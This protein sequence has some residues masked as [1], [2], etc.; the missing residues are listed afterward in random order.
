M[1]IVGY[2]TAANIASIASVAT[3]T[4][5]SPFNIKL[6]GSATHMG[7][8]CQ[9]AVSY[10]QGATFAVIA[11]VIGGCPIDESYTIPSLPPLPS[12]TKALFAWAWQ[13]KVGNRETYGNCAI[14]DIVGTGTS[15]TGPKLFRANSVPD[16]TCRTLGGQEGEH[17]S[18]FLFQ[19]QL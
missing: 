11:S 4:A 18:C 7:G 8:S 17:G 15:Y 5:G 12:A 1:R 6:G 9:F 2:N 19:G 3:L 14:V 13:N 16:G 10:D